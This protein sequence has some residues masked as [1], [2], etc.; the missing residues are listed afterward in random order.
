MSSSKLFQYVGALVFLLLALVSL[1][2][3]LFWFPITIAGEEVGQTTSFFA[4]VIFVAL[5]L[6]LF[7]GVRER[8][9]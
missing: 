1:Y 3:L 5:S 7:R 6:M 8:A 2:R 4:L 9:D